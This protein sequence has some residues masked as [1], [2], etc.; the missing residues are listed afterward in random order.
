MFHLL[1]I[2]R[3]NGSVDR[4]IDLGLEYSQIAKYVLE[5]I[6]NGYIINNDGI[7]ELTDLGQSKMEELKEKIYQISPG[8]WI[9]PEEKSRIDKI[10][11]FDIY[12]PNRENLGF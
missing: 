12:L 9:I 8:K 11:K 4:L 6:E 5:A 1:H 2:T 10:G 3:Y 7:L